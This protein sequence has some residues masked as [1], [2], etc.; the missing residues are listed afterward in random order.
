MKAITV[1][2]P[3]SLRIRRACLRQIKRRPR[4]PNE[5][6]WRPINRHHV[7]SLDRA[8]AAQRTNLPENSRLQQAKPTPEG[9]F[10]HW[11]DGPQ[12]PFNESAR[13]L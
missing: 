8:Y 9:D 7:E 11:G 6:P 13:A 10:K 1:V 2:Y 3:P 4:I 5:T 12:A